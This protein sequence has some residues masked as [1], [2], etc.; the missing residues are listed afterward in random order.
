MGQSQISGVKDYVA[1]AK[2]YMDD[3]LSGK[4]PA[5]QWVKK[6]VNRQ[7]KDLLRK[8]WTYHFSPRHACKVCYFVEH[9]KHV[10]GELAGQCIE[11]QPWQVFIITTVFGWVDA[12]GRRR[13]RHV[14]IEVPRGNGK[15]ALSSAIALYALAADNEAG[16]ECYSFATTRDQTKAVF[17]TAQLMA[18][19]SPD[20]C[21]A[22]GITVNAKT[23]TVLRNG[24][25][26]E[27]KSADA[28]SL[29]GLITHFA[30]VDE[31]HAHKTRAVYDVVETSIGKRAQPLLWVITTAGFDTTGI[32]YEVRSLVTKVLDGIVEDESRFGIIF[33]I[34]EEDDWKTERAC[35][36]ANPNWGVSVMPENVLDLLK[37]AINLP[38]AANNFKTK[39]LNVWCSASTAWMDMPAWQQCQQP[40]SVEEFSGEKCFI[41]LDLGAKNDITA[42]VKVFPQQ[43]DDGNMKLYVFCDFYLPRSA[44][45]RSA[46]ASYQGWDTLGLL[47][48]TEGA[49][50]DFAQIEA[51]IRDDLSRYDVQAVAYDPW[52][53]TQM[54]MA[55]SDDGAPMV[56][57]RNT[58]QNMSDPM[59]MLEALVQNGSIVH[60]DDPVMT[61]MMGN[62]VARLDAKDNIFPRK[63]HYDKK[64]DGPVA[65]IM[66]LGV[67]LSGV[68]NATGKFDE[69]VDDIIVI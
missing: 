14:Y 15:S 21:K 20:V 69:F 68:E 66:A 67:C 38:S 5:C 51:D 34:D 47:H 42:K 41:G 1:I 23:I 24:S 56:E 60:P 18:K 59:K 55:L 62:V 9:L 52:Q 65:L 33:T 11:L 7:K 37:K 16:A 10:K 2:Q 8:V 54:A 28:S 3:V 39:H 44:I 46:N 12:R 57:F 26:L 53:M 63:E 27:A 4:V 19:A 35:I 48:V 13:F 49:V 50:S 30:C 64:I 32:C 40:V 25:V 58:V 6:A 31:L 36:K 61:W 22:L 43:D 17:Q 45:E 29:D